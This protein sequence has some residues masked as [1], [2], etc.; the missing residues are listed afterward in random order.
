MC[1][2]LLAG[3]VRIQTLRGIRVLRRETPV[4]LFEELRLGRNGHERMVP[5]QAGSVKVLRGKNAMPFWT[6]VAERRL[7]ARSHSDN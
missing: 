3:V 1:P 7:P 5:P 6:I 4:D 2:L